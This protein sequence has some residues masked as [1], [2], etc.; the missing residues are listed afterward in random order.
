MR[1]R[2]TIAIIGTVLA[3]LVVAGLGTLAFASA[4]ARKQSEREVRDQAEATASILDIS[5][6]AADADGARLLPRERFNRVRNALELEDLSLVVLRADNTIGAELS[7]PLPDRLTAERLQPEN[8]RGG[9]VTSGSIGDEVFAAAPL[10]ET[11]GSLAVV[12]LTRRVDRV[13]GPAVGWFFLASLIAIAVA[14]L[15][16][17]RLAKQLTKPLRS[18]TEATARIADGDMSVRLPTETKRRDDEITEL[19]RSINQMATTLQR[20]RGL[21]Q[22]F[23]LSVS[24]DLRTPLTSIRG[25]AEAVADGTA[26]DSQA[27]AGVILAEARRLERLVKDLLDLAK[28]EARQFALDIVPVDLAELARR[29]AEGFAREAGEAGV[30]LTVVAPDHSVMVAA[31]PDR[32]GQVLANLTEN[33][34]KY[35]TGRIEVTVVDHPVGPRLEVSDDGAGVAAEDL[36]HVFERLYVAKWE[37]VRKESGSGLGLAIVRELIEAMGGHVTAAAN[38]GGGTRMV[39]V[40]PP[41]G[42]ASPSDRGAQGAVRPF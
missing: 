8:L 2:F 36:P 10:T 31:D 42:G 22:Q 25:Y 30:A 16:A 7:D 20:S 3:T 14:A 32:L 21:E 35:A 1:R 33:S 26:S 5:R 13:L 6:V 24:H 9:E 34:L 18:A 19:S 11:R 28:L 40:F 17:F 15:V 4:G 38:A 23:L 29:G 12:V 37:P 41:G 27:A 39:V